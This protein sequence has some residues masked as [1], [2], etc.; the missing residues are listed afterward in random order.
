MRQTLQLSPKVYS[1]GLRESIADIIARRFRKDS[2]THSPSKITNAFKIG[3]QAF[4]L[5]VDSNNGSEKATNEITSLVQRYHD[6]YEREQKRTALIKLAVE[7]ERQQSGVKLRKAHV[8]SPGE[9]AG[10][11][12]RDILTWPKRYKDFEHKSFKGRRQIPYLVESQGFPF[13]RFHK[14]M[15]QR[16]AHTINSKKRQQR[17]RFA[18]REKLGGL[19]Q[20]GE[21][22]DQW[23][24]ILQEEFNMDDLRDEEHSWIQDT[25]EVDRELYKIFVE[26]YQRTFEMGKR[27]LEIT[28]REREL[29][30]IENK[31]SLGQGKDQDRQESEIDRMSSSIGNSRQTMKR[32]PS[33]SRRRGDLPQSLEIDEDKPS[34]E[35]S[36]L[37]KRS[38]NHY[39][40]RPMLNYLSRN[41]APEDSSSNK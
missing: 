14:P 34:E 38:N 13:L 9:A 6:L 16:L 31:V 12:P 29:L 33:D 30:E 27:M 24:S 32:L 15:P 8:L 35:T 17:S 41:Q 37:H 39:T 20:F 7:T 2:Q 10:T 21:E 40:F 36:S 5:L 28:I 22:E 1:T 23:D 4:D 11:K 26:S 18:Q 19:I 3:Y 25:D